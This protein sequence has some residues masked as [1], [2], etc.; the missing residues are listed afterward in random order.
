MEPNDRNLI[1]PATLGDTQGVG[2]GSAESN[3]VL[4]RGMPIAVSHTEAA[5]DA[6]LAPGIQS[7][8]KKLLNRHESVDVLALASTDRSQ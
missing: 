3:G 4:R 7:T 8:N 6:Q 5:Y 2:A 1:H